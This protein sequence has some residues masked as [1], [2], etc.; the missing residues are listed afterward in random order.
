MGENRWGCGASKGRKLIRLCLCL[1]V[2]AGLSVD[3]WSLNSVGR[4]S[5]LMVTPHVSAKSAISRLIRLWYSKIAVAL[6]S[7]MR[8]TCSRM[9]LVTLAKAE[10]YAV[11]GR[12][13][14]ILNLLIFG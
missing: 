9:T 13:P 2:L 7:S 4:T 10:V 14:V 11:K 3:G 6:F 1:L 12:C 5:I 8:R